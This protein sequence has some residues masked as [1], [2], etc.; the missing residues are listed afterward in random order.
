VKEAD[1]RFVDQAIRREKVFRVLM[2]VGVVV[3]L[4]LLGWAIRLATSGQPWGTTFV[5]AIL[6]LLSARGN[7][8]Q[9]KF[10]RILRELR[11]R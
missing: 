7:L 6:V 4:G 5:L 1:A 3:G 11:E 9:A 10:A 8:R 2:A